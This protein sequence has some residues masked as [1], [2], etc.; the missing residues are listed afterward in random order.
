MLLLHPYLHVNTG[1]NGLFSVSS[2]R[3]PGTRAN[4]GCPP[5]KPPPLPDPHTPTS[6]LPPSQGPQGLSAGGRQP[7][8]GQRKDPLPGLGG[9]FHRGAPPPAPGTYTRP[10]GVRSGCA[11][12]PGR[13]RTRRRPRPAAPGPRPGP[14]PAAAAWP[15][16]TELMVPPASAGPGPA[17][18]GRRD[19]LGPSRRGNPAAPT[20]RLSA[21]AATWGSGG[22]NPFFSTEFYFPGWGWTGRG[23]RSEVSGR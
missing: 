7:G 13:R 23:L 4:P 11:T 2:K 14:G 22:G 8:A 5:P 10:Q 21:G 1:E 12:P 19:V 17:P 3:T 15:P 16:C 9:R 18:T 20:A 6:R